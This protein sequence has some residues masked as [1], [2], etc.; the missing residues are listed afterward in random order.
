MTNETSYRMNLTKKQMAREFENRIKDTL[1]EF[2]QFQN[3]SSKN[4]NLNVQQIF[5]R[6][7]RTVKG[8]GIDNCSAIT[9]IFKTP[10]L[11]SLCFEKCDESDG[12]KENLLNA[13]KL[14]L[15]KN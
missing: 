7:L 15:M 1:I 4:S 12:Q 5:A 13:G 9:R 3:E 2:K 8:L 11:L 6:Q 14:E 10:L